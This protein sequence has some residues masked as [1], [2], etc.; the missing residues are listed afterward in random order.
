M[1]DVDEYGVDEYEV[2]EYE[3][4]LLTPSFDRGAR[5]SRTALSEMGMVPILPTEPDWAE[6]CRGETA[7]TANTPVTTATIRRPDNR[8]FCR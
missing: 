7:I 6:T 3:V 5:K 1:Y 8:L 4:E 2:D